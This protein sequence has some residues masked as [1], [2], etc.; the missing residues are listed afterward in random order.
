MTLIREYNHKKPDTVDSLQTEMWNQDL[1][2][3]SVNATVW[4]VGAS[5][6]L[7]SYIQ[8]SLKFCSPTLH[9]HLPLVF[10]HNALT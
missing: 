10:S 1:L 5:P 6:N 8:S 7:H 4:W 2:V 9:H 3:L